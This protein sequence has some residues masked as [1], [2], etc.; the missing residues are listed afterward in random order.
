MSIPK[1]ES[2]LTVQWL[3][4]IFHDYGSIADFA[5]ERVSGH[6]GMTAS[7]VRLRLKFD[8]NAE[9]GAPKSVIVKFASQVMPDF[10]YQYFYPSEHG[11]YQSHLADPNLIPLAK[12]YYSSC[13]PQEKSFILV[14][15][16]LNGYH[17][18]SLNHGF[19]EKR[20][21]NTVTFLARLH[22]EW[23]EKPI[24]DAHWLKG[25][26]IQLMI[27]NGDYPKLALLQL[28]RTVQNDFL[29]YISVNIDKIIETAKRLQRTATEP[30]VTFIHGDSQFGNL[31]F[32]DND[33][34]AAVIDWQLPARIKGV[35]DL[36]SLIGLSIPSMVRRKYEHN[37]LDQYLN[38]LTDSG[39]SGYGADQL[40]LDYSI[41]LFYCGFRLLG[42]CAATFNG[43]EEH[44]IWAKECLDRVQSFFE[45]WKIWRTVGIDQ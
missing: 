18:G 29:D 21:M 11:F 12:C 6:T 3:Q 44:L 30:P 13:N 7:L 1:N 20:L 16:D 36:S 42:A 10:I 17:S 40:R 26:M 19:T 31:F 22:S 32:D 37:L 33:A 4:G 38:Q 9:S 8:S 34:L 23:W 41:A 39:V 25:H 27:A 28:S 24:A 5:V 43:S 35:Y 45:D 2:E 15:E 14:L